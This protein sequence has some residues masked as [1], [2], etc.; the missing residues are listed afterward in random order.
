MIP[1]HIIMKTAAAQTERQQTESAATAADYAFRNTPPPARLPG[2][3][4]NTKHLIEQK[5]DVP[6]ALTLT[7]VLSV[8]NHAKGSHPDGKKPNAKTRAKNM[9]KGRL[10]PSAAFARAPVSAAADIDCHLRKS[11]PRTDMGLGKLVAESYSGCKIS[12]GK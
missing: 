1:L 2:N 9:K 6:E 11:I 5:A 10:D 12:G 3:A 8:L 4:W 7:P